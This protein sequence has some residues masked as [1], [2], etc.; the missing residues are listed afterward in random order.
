MR[1]GRRID[2]NGRNIFYFWDTP[3][4]LP[5]VFEKN[6]SHSRKS[7]RKWTVHL[8]GDK[9]IRELLVDDPELLALY[10]KIRIPACRADLARLVLLH[11]YGGWYIDADIP[12]LGDIDQFGTARPVL[13]RRDD[14][15]AEKHGF[16]GRITNMLF[17]APKGSA[18][19]AEAIECIRRNAAEGHA[20]YNVTLF[21]GPMMI[22]ALVKKLGVP[23]AQLHS[24]RDAFDEESGVFGTSHDKSV[25]SWQLQQHFGI[26]DGLP[27]KL[28]AFPEEIT[29]RFAEILTEFVRKHD[30]RREFFELLALRPEYLKHQACLETVRDF[31]PSAM[32]AKLKPQSSTLPASAAPLRTGPSRT[33]IVHIGDHKTGTTALQHALARNQ[34]KIDG[35]IPF[36]GS[37]LNHNHLP[38]LARALNSLDGKASEHAK[39]QFTNLAK[40]MRESKSPVCILSA[41]EFEHFKPKQLRRLIDSY[42]ADQFDQ[43]KIVAYVRPHLPRL[44]SEYAERTKI[45]RLQD[46]MEAFYAQC[47]RGGVLTYT[48]RFEAWRAA[49]GADFIL[50]PAQRS[51]QRDGV[52]LVDF[53]SA[54]LGPVEITA[55]AEDQV[56]ESLSLEDLLRVKFLHARINGRPEQ[57]H[58]SFGW[59]L[60]RMVG[61][62]SDDTARTRL[63]MHRALAERAAA[64]FHDDATRMDEAFFA[65]QPWMAAAITQAVDEAC[66]T[67]QP[68]LAEDLFAASE[69]RS[70]E[71]SARL[72]AE[73]LTN[74]AEPW[75]KHF[76]QNRLKALHGEAGG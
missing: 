13:F 8:V 6:L 67:P 60:A 18:F 45:G 35:K 64:Q 70:L 39:S 14:A 63:R 24:Y 28:N 49:F 71:L 54:A 31:N 61:T 52:L 43:V 34:V 10:N 40:R 12:I 55:E 66:D 5:D 44:V 51:L 29:K 47:L 38:N 22:S 9:K 37:R 32:A 17:Y 15:F 2:A 4:N 30:L 69:L 50:R 46:D 72:I 19:V 58:H 65:D 7:A 33:L 75:T 62:L 25:S 11:R 73:M 76:H 56:N 1:L 48:P 68:A 23:E 36:Y 57:F 41:E 74:N 16:T 20:L 3:K 53:L 42:F 21:S 26:F 59:A 27:P